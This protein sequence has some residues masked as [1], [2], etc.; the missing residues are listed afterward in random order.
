LQFEG[1]IY[2]IVAR[3]DGRRALFHDEGH[4]DRLTG[5]LADEVTRS[6]WQVIAYCWMPN[7]IHV[8][9]RTPRPNLSSGMQHW[10]SGYANWH[11]KRNRRS[12]HLFQG[13]YQS[14]LVE[15]SSYFWSLSR[16]IHLNPCRGR[17][18][19][20]E[21]PEQW[22]GSSYAGY[23]R[24]SGRQEFV[25]YERLLAAWRGEH[26][27][28]D[29]AAAYRRYIAQGLAGAL[30]NPLKSALR[31]WVIGS[32][33]FMQRMLAKAR[34]RNTKGASRA[35]QYR[36]A[37]VDQ[38]IKAVAQ[39]HGVDPQQY[40]GFRVHA[41][42]REMAALVCRKHTSATLAELSTRFGLNHPD[43]A[44]NLVRRAKRLSARSPGYRRKLQQLE[45][46][47]KTEKQV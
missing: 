43:S 29:A 44:A 11:A 23:Y 30:E 40:A 25:Q 10:L 27:G 15:D 32:D 14:F 18:P 35:R 41:A 24:R 28:Q 31:E 33:K 8:L 37:N 9:L 26:G 16:Y 36:A 4:Y 42:G 19:L 20:V 1:A 2:H 12:G 46:R 22:P 45:A 39:A 34:G 47:L 7:H 17:A 5:G 38:V 3:G 21:R 6:G 13:R